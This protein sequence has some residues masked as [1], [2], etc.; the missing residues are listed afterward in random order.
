[1]GKGNEWETFFNGHAQKYM[2]EPFTKNTK[3]EIEFILE[4][5]KLKEN[6]KIL[7]VGCGTGR[8]SIE[9]AG[10]GFQV[11]GVDISSGMLAEAKKTAKKAGV[12]IT[13]IHAD[14]KHFRPD[15][16]FDAALCLCEG[17]FGLLSS[18]DNPIEHDLDILRN[19]NTAL[20]PKAKIILTTPNGF[21]KIRKYSQEDVE[22]GKFDPLTT[23]ENFG[24][25]CET[26]SGK[27]R[28]SVRER[29]YIPTELTLL[30]NQAGFKVD[31][32]WGGTAGNWRRQK[33]NLDEIEI[34]VV[35]IKATSKDDFDS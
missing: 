12:T 16:K 14:A 31:H 26:P 22:T 30:F 7:D 35:A 20:K 24:I 33:I 8:H 3:E 13:W 11:T 17:A 25:E 6:S 15:R 27:K 9:L 29:G 23:V 21:Q 34:M 2:N 32:I 10:R 18:T 4:E 28:V 5:L 19:I 1:M